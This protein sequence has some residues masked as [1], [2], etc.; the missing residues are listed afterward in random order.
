MAGSSGSPFKT[1][2]GSSTER[3][4]YDVLNLPFECS[5]EALKE[6]SK[7]LFLELHPDRCKGGTTKQSLER[8]HEVQAAWKCLS[9]PTKR[10][11]YDLRNFGR[12]SIDNVDGISAEAQLREMQQEQALRDVENMQVIRENVLKREK[13]RQGLIVEKAIY[14]NLALKPELMMGAL[15]RKHVEETDIEGPVCDVTVPLQCMVERHMIMIPG[16]V[17][18]SKAD[19]TGFYNPSPLS[20]V[21]NSV[22]VLYWFRNAL[23]EVTV[24]D[25]DKLALPLRD[26]KVSAN[27]PRGP[28]PSTNIA[29]MAEMHMNEE[30][31]APQQGAAAISEESPH[32][33]EM[34]G[35]RKAVKEYRLAAGKGNVSILDAFGLS[36][37][38]VAALSWLMK[39]S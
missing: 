30:A 10:L 33:S 29:R 39:R 32:E 13:A 12:S 4:Y 24:G 5:Q 38:C 25:H 19:L 21:E 35:F 28:F 34:A 1:P 26:H 20:D 3:S 17:S 6:V 8:F 2:R 14:G 16:S 7:R 9:D 11:L 27:G 22:Y 31:A 18:S 37:L 15:Q 36:I 23:H